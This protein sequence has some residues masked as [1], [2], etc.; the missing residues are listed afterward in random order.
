MHP[1]RSG[2]R[3]NDIL[4]RH[5]AQAKS[6]VSA[7]P[8]QATRPD[9]SHG[10]N[11]EFSAPESFP[12]IMNYDNSMQQALQPFGFPLMPFGGGFFGMD[13]L[14]PFGRDMD[15]TSIA[16]NIFDGSGN[17]CQ[18]SSVMVV[19][20][21]V[22][23]DGQQHVE[24]YA[25]SSASNPSRQVHEM[26]EAYTNSHSGVDKIAYERKLGDRGQRI[27]KERNRRTEETITNDEVIGMDRADEAVQQFND[28]W[29]AEAS[30]ALPVRAALPGVDRHYTHPLGLQHDHRQRQGPPPQYLAEGRP[31]RR[32]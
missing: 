25:R 5:P 26:K 4:E 17:A 12:P 22:G 6:S 8:R 7:Y 10:Y 15:V 30:R 13:S 19:N 16:N 3:N 24:K 21:S 31:L 32:A 11:G 27:S 14:F 20:S 23:P 1:Q 29:A 28:Q 18:Y 2:H 9:Y